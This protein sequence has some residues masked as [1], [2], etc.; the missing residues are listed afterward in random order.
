[1]YRSTI[2]FRYMKPFFTSFKSL[3]TSFKTL[4]NLGFY[5]MEREKQVFKEVF[6]VRKEVKKVK[7]I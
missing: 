1:M 5:D 6:Q 3:S 2:Y 7:I 4:K